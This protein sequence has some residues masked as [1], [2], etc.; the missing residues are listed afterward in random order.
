M[1][2]WAFPLIAVLGAGSF[3]LD[4]LLFGGSGAGVRLAGAGRKGTAATV[5]AGR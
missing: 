5:A 4:G 2:C 3:S 1:F